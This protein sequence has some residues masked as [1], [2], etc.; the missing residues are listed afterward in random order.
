MFQSWD[1]DRWWMLLVIDFGISRLGAGLL[2]FSRHVC[3]F[4]ESSLSLRS[5]GFGEICFGGL[6]G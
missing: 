4:Y 1:R 2:L 6:T 3:F 5:D